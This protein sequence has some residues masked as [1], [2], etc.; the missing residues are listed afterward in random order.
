M[1]L[2]IPT[3]AVRWYSGILLVGVFF[4][5]LTMSVGAGEL[6][7]EYDALGRLVRVT[8]DQGNV[9][10]YTYDAVGNILSIVHA[11]TAEIPVI[12]AISPD[13]VSRGE[14]VGV[15]ITGDNLD[16]ASLFVANPEIDVSHV[17]SSANEVTATLIVSSAAPLGPATLTVTTGLGPASTDITVNDVLPKVTSVTPSRG[18]PSGGTSITLN[19]SSFSSDVTATIGGASVADLVLVNENSLTGT[20]PPGTQGSADVVVTNSEGNFTLPDGFL[21]GA[22]FTVPGAL[23]LS[24][25]STGTLVV[26]LD[27]PTT[28]E[29][30]VTFLSN[31]TDV[32]TVSGGAVIPISGV[33]V[34]VPLT[35]VADGT[36]FVS[37]T[38]DGVSLSTSVHVSPPFVGNLDI[39]A[40]SVGSVLPAPPV[41]SP[42]GVVLP[43]F[44][45]P[46]A[47]VA[48]G[49]AKTV[50][51]QLSVP[52]PVG[53]LC[54]A[55]VSSNEAVA[56]VPA[57]M[58]IGE[59]EQTVTFEITGV[60][61]GEALI[62]A[63]AGS[64][65]FE[66]RALVDRSLPNPG[67][68]VAS[69]VGTLVTPTVEGPTFA[70]IVGVEVQE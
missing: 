6:Q 53:G 50:T 19:G 69:P 14:V 22:I 35:S 13:V 9:T 43:A 25:G 61:G 58:C 44:P 21:Y 38:V 60:S 64:E 8:D 33:Q 70:P 54:I 12:T 29:L 57:E 48:S 5:S 36:T 7:Y 67:T 40:G 56:T 45:L 23:A 47:L 18:T 68:V 1:R 24:T 34:S 15:T 11:T 51:L 52:A 26:S 66:V 37:T 27:E 30:P 55:L 49:S 20:S 10:A 17:T 32:V 39:V 28:V 42:V 65:V 4:F 31:D 3:P 46:T 41:A 59:G 2:F 16:G 63:T 62:T